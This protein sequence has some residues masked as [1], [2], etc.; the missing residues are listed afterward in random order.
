MSISLPKCAFISWLPSDFST[1]TKI[2]IIENRIKITWDTV[3]PA[4]LKVEGDQVH[5]EA[6]VL[7]LE[8]VV[9]YLAKDRIY[10]NVFQSE[11]KSFMKKEEIK[12]NRDI[13]R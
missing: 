3:V 12:E 4:S 11:R 10:K 7:G 5:A 8:Q 6:G 2:N 9:R 13:G 1:I